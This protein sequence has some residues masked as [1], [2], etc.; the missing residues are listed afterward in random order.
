MNPLPDGKV[1]IRIADSQE[2]LLVHDDQVEKVII[3]CS[4]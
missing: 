2:I 4:N 1:R 3:T